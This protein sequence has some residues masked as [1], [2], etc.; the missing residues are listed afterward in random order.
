MADIPKRRKPTGMTGPTI[1]GP[2][3]VFT[4]WVEFPKT[5]AEV[6][7]F[8]AK[9]FCIDGPGYRPH[10]KRYGNFSS[11]EAQNEN[12]I[13]FYVTT[14]LG[15]RW[16]ELCEFAPLVEFGGS[17]DNVPQNW[18]ARRMSELVLALI[19]R[20]AEKKYG[21][22]TLLLIYKTHRTLFVPPPIIRAVR[23]ELNGCAPS[24][25]SIYYISP[26]SSEE[27]SVWEIWPGDPDD[28][29]PLICAGNLLVGP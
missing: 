20:K 9:G 24:F 26:H 6:E 12:S 22:D 2:D 4:K 7:L 25:E 5:K 11:L 29:G 21:N 1:F 16:L 19:A 23:R 17:Y 14:G 15:G 27:M 28:Q 18:D 13:D 8:I 3:G 10:F